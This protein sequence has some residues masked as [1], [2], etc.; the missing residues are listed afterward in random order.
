M[1]LIPKFGLGEGAVL[2][3]FDPAPQRSKGQTVMRTFP[4]RT[5]QH[6]GKVVQIK[7]SIM[8]DTGWCFKCAKLICLECVDKGAC[9]PIEAKLG[10][11]E[12]S[13]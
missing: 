11:W 4:T 3:Y 5:C 2:E 7:R 6:C 1:V 12:G 10:R 8:E 9:D 13:K